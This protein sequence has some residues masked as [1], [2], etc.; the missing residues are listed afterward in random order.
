[1]VVEE[2]QQRRAGNGLLVAK[3]SGEE[4]SIRPFRSY[5]DIHIK[6]I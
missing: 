5:V 4:M 3:E 2:G 1:M 6:V